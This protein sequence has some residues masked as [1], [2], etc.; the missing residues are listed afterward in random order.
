LKLSE[1]AA[2]LSSTVLQQVHEEVQG[3]V[4]GKWVR[5]YELDLLRAMMQNVTNE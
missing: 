5:G 3:D 2:A 1:E 4:V